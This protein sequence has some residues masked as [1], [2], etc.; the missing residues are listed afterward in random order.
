MSQVTTPTEPGWLP[1]PSG[2]SC[3][4]GRREDLEEEDPHH[5]DIARLLVRDV[6]LAEGHRGGREQGQDRGP[7]PQ[8]RPPVACR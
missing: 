3:R 2:R 7:R 6:S 8:R 1:D 5:R 4:V